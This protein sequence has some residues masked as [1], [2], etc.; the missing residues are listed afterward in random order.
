MYE[1]GY[2]HA[3]ERPTVLICSTPLEDLPFDIRNWHVLSYEKGKTFGLRD[4]LAKQVR[5]V[6]EQRC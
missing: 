2:A 4:R 3:L 1:V 5:A 6:I